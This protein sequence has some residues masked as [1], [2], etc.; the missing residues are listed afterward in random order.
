MNNHQQPGTPQQPEHNGWQ[1]PEAPVPG[2]DVEQQQTTPY[3]PQPGQHYQQNQ[4]GQPEFGQPPYPPQADQYNFGQPP[5]GDP[6]HGHYGQPG[7]GQFGPT[8]PKRR[9]PVWGWVVAGIG[10]LAILAFG[11]LML[12]GAIVQASQASPTPKP[13]ETAGSSESAG[14]TEEAT[15]DG[16]SA[17]PVDDA[18]YLF[19]D[20]DFTSAPVW[21]TAMPAG[22]TMSDAKSGT[23]TYRNSENGCMFTTHQAILPPRSAVTDEEA[24]KTSMQIEMEGIKKAAAS[25]VTVV[26]DADSLYTKLR[27]ADG[28]TIELQEAELQFKNKSNVDLVYRMAIRSMPAGDGLMELILV[29]PASLPTESE[30]WT[31]LTDSVTMVDDPAA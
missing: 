6:G 21:S 19:E 20:A 17:A 13:T 3:P 28:R 14:A 31:E 24:T 16:S 10:T 9:F 23:F 29:C 1:H 26:T 5:Y 22:W 11:G 7:P 2:P 15:T 30:V 8:P 25:P 12:L 18:T 27:N 4:Q